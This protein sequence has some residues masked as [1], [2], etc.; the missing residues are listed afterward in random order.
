MACPAAT[1]IPRVV[2]SSRV[3]SGAG[4]CVRVGGPGDIHRTAWRWSGPL[5]DTDMEQCL[6]VMYSAVTETWFLA[7]ESRSERWDQKVGNVGNVRSDGG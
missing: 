3:L 1:C 6:R 5:V 7:V 4:S 2:K